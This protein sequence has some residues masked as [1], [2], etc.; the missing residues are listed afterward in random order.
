MLLRGQGENQSKLT[1]IR[2]SVFCFLMVVSILAPSLAAEIKRKDFA[3]TGGAGQLHIRE[4]RN[5][6]AKGIR[7]IL[8]V[9][10]GGPGGIPSF[11]QP[12]PGYSL[13]EDLARKGYRVFVMDVRGW[14]SSSR[15]PE[16]DLPAE[17]GVPLVSTKEAADDIATVVAWI[18]SRT[19]RKVAVMGWASGGHWACAYASREPKDL[20][21]LILLNSLYADSAPWDLR[22]SLQDKNDP[23]QFDRHAGSYRLADRNS[24]LRR[25]DASIPGPDKTIWREPSVAEAYVR[26][27]LESDPTS[28]R[29]NPPS[30]RIPIG[31]L[32]DAFD[33]SLGRSLFNAARIRVPT[34]GI[35]GELDFWSR[36]ADL[37]ALR[38]DLA[39]ARG[40]TTVTIPGGTHYLFL[41][42]PNR[43]RTR[44]LDEV[45]KFLH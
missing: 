7:N 43:G 23:E 1:V 31:Y 34:L 20:S 22:S 5:A 3:I 25:W 28:S 33:L 17:R 9:H 36:S 38:R 29:R 13:A 45:E 18:F 10:G 16:M 30:V 14:G 27:T 6:E 42:R 44:F 40:V 8:L 37:D 24:L 19:H 35:R 15:P 32:H 26:L 4:V 21:H 41:D 11:D 12:A 39:N 2:R